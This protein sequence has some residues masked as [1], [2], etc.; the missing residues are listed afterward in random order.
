MMFN[1]KHGPQ[2]N[3]FI[4]IPIVPFPVQTRGEILSKSIYGLTINTFLCGILR[5]LHFLAETSGV[6][7]N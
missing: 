1:K 6:F 2:G 4:F 7:K 3:L 5:F